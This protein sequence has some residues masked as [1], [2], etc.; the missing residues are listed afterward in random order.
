M[1]QPLDLA[2]SNFASMQ[3]WLDKS[4]AKNNEYWA[5]LPTLQDRLIVIQVDLD[6]LQAKR[7][8]LEVDHQ[9][10]ETNWKLLELT[11]AMDACKLIITIEW[12]KHL[13]KENVDLDV[14][15]CS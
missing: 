2:K 10:V 3:S 9:K 8:K 14:R 12:T 1:I 11:I 6:R 7:T 15:L 13:K 4:L 5:Q